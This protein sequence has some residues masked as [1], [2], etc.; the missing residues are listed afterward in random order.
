M[1]LRLLLSSARSG[2]G[3]DNP[4]GGLLLLLHQLWWRRRDGGSGGGGDN[5]A[6]HQLQLLLN[7]AN[8]GLVL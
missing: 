1:L 7:G 3:A 2:P 4:A 5:G 6:F 8:L